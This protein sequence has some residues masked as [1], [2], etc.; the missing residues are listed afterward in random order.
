MQPATVAEP[1]PDLEVGARQLPGSFNTQLWSAAGDGVNDAAASFGGGRV[2][3]WKPA[4]GAGLLIRLG[5]MP[6]S[7]LQPDR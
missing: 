5:S 1:E 2:P 4:A 7:P 6:A 3:D